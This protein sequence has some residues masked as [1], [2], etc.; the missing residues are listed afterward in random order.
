MCIPRRRLKLLFMLL[1]SSYKVDED[2]TVD[3]RLVYANINI[4]F[5]ISGSYK[6][7][8]YRY[9]IERGASVYS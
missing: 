3:Q 9:G 7:I 6:R 2:V 8:W 1:D 4:K 5:P